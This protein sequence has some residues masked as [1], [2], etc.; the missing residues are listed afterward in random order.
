MEAVGRLNNFN[1]IKEHCK[2]LIKEGNIHVHTDIIAGLPLEDLQSFQQ[3]FN[4]VSQIYGHM[5]QVGFW[6]INRKVDTNS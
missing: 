5:F 2:G 1:K 3:S 4:D 6:S